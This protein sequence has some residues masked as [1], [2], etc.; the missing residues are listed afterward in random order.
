MELSAVQETARAVRKLYA[1]R[2]RVRHGRTWT[3][4]ELV[5]GFVG[6]V[7]D[8]A[9][10]ALGKAGVRPR[11]DLH[12]AVAHELADRLWSLCVLADS[13]GVDLEV[14][15]G[16]TMRSLTEQLEHAGREQAVAAEHPCPEACEDP[17]A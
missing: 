6:D 8:L 17:E 15:F 9:K 10:L 13:Y 4:E 12:E 16:G 3:A 14:A 2:D 7:G 11:D 1:D 5:L